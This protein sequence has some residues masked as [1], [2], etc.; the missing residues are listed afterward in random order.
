MIPQ[1]SFYL[2][3]HGES[4]A[5]LAGKAAGGG[6]DSLLTPK[7]ESQARDLAE[8]I[9]NLGIKPS[10]IFASPMKRAKRTAE[11]V[12]EGLNLKLTIVD[13]LEEH[14]VGE[15]EG[16]PWG[17][18]G[19]KMEAGEIPPGGENYDQYA[20]RVG[21]VLTPLL[22]RKYETPPLIVAHGGTFRAI[23]HL[24]NWEIRRVQNCHLHR[25]DPCPDL[26]AFPF[27]IF[28]YNVA[29]IDLRECKSSFC[30]SIR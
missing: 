22:E 12:N 15:W 8:V 6:V 26:K 27:R 17:L 21:R 13:N 9:H 29:G 5:N 28:E 10:V 3:R 30:S 11:I 18:I 2:L 14:H 16:Q 1:T 7:G 19:P 23:G 25:F 20:E 4:E 24:Y